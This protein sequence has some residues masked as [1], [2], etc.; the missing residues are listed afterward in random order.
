M[1]EALSIVS[2]EK[3][4]SKM[5]GGRGSNTLPFV[6]PRRSKSKQALLVQRKAGWRCGGAV[7]V[8]HGRYC[9]TECIFD[10]EISVETKSDR[11]FCFSLS[12]YSAQLRSLRPG[13]WFLGFWFSN[14]VCVSC[15]VRT[16]VFKNRSVPSW[17]Q[18]RENVR[19]ESQIC[20]PTK[21]T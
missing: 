12:L 10:S 3:W 8:T 6:V 9:T 16:S 19:V 20:L 2:V 5:Q 21:R 17:W 4:L 1:E 18:R 11:L 14:A 15:P 7:I 13:N